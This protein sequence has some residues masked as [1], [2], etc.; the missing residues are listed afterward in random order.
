MLKTKGTKMEVWMI[1]VIISIIA[2]IIEIL[3][4][5]LF[6]INFAIAGIIT[7]II[8]IFRFNLQTL[9]LIFFG[10]SLISIIFIKPILE[11]MLNKNDVDFNSQYIGKTVK[12]I[13][14]IT[15]TQGAITLYDERWEARLKN[16]CEPIPVGCEVKIVS[17]E[18]LILFVERI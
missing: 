12:V 7:A 15:A 13:E 1:F 11:K 9:I 17:N 10:I 3:V 6:C 4:P 18:G 2:L 8:A 14:E 16:D 5:T